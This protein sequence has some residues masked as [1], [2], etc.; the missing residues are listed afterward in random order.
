MHKL[1]LEGM[2]AWTRLQY[3]S[4][5]VRAGGG[6]CRLGRS[7]HPSQH[8]REPNWWEGEERS[9]FYWGI[10]MIQA[11][12]ENS[13]SKNAPDTCRN[14]SLALTVPSQFSQAVQ[15]EHLSESTESIIE[16]EN[17]LELGKWGY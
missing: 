17:Q 6:S 12:P 7:I 9:R 8:A 2:P 10:V 11:G 1:G 14:K 3:S 4:V 13:P 5:S 16:K 15:I